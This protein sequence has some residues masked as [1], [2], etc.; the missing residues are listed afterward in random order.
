MEKNEIFDIIVKNTKA[1]VPALKDSEFS[2]STTAMSLGINPLD[3]NEILLMTIEA[4]D[5]PITVMQLQ[6]ARNYG[7][8]AELLYQKVIK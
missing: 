1:V 4:M 2:D 6:N 8:L 7:D 3:Q 5:T